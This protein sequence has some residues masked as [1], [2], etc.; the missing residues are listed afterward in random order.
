MKF[1]SKIGWW[2]HLTVLSVVAGGCALPIAIGVK[3]NSIYA[4]V[5]GMIV[6]TSTLVLVFPAYLNTHYILDDDA[7][8]IRSGLLVNKKIPYQDIE[9]IC[10]TKDPSASVGLSLDRISIRYTEGEVLISPKNKQA[11]IR[12][13]Q[14]RIA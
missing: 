10:E 5:V 12:L 3:S 11:F 7:L 9:S 6:A 13:L 8:R 4:V 2:F 14:Q 1:K